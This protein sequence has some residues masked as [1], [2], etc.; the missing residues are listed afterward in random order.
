[1]II[2][3]K[4]VYLLW[5]SVN[6]LQILPYPLCQASSTYLTSSTLRSK[7]FLNCNIKISQMISESTPYVSFYIRLSAEMVSTWRLNFFLSWDYGEN[8]M[9]GHLLADLLHKE[10]A[11]FKIKQHFSRTLIHISYKILMIFYNIV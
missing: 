4:M 11:V 10:L 3:I 2:Q 1:M 8:I 7:L 9:N 6:T 5:A